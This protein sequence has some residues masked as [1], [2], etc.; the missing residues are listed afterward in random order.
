MMWVWVWRYLEE[1]GGRKGLNE[2]EGVCGSR[3]CGVEDVSVGV[4]VV[5]VVAVVVAVV[6]VVVVVVVV[7]VAVVMVVVVMVVGEA[8][9]QKHLYFHAQM[10]GLH[11]STAWTPPS[12]H[13]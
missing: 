11:V 9:Q 6:V 5:D 8:F 13:W 10:L 2:G 3:V 1:W 12:H 7:M 4:A